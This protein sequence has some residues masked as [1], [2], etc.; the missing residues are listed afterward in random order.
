MGSRA[1][2]FMAAMLVALP[3]TSGLGASPSLAAGAVTPEG[4]CWAYVPDSDAEV[5]AGADEADS[6]F[7][8]VLASDISTQLQP[9]GLD[10]PVQTRLA[11][12]VSPDTQSSGIQGYRLTLDDGPVVVPAVP[13]DPA[14]PAPPQF[15]VE[16]EENQPAAVQVKATALFSI[17]P[18]EGLARD[19]APQLLRSPSEVVDLRP[20]APVDGLVF[21]APLPAASEGKKV[22]RLDTLVFE[23]PGEN[24]TD[25]GSV[26]VCN[27]QTEG[28]PSFPM[29]VDPAD[30]IDE[31]VPGIN[32]ATTPVPTGATAEFTPT[33]VRSV[34][35]AKVQG[36]SVTTA[37]RTGDTIEL[38]IAGLGPD[39]AFTARLC[40]S[41]GQ[42]AVEVC[43][44]ADEELVTDATGAASTSLTVPD[45]L[46]PGNAKIKIASG[47]VTQLEM[48]LAVLGPPTVA[49]SEVL[50]ADSVEVTLEGADWDPAGAVKIKG[51]VDDEKMSG[52]KGL[53][54][55]VNSDGTFSATFEVTD[56]RATQVRVQQDR[57]SGFEILEVRQAL[58]NQVPGVKSPPSEPNK[59]A[60]PQPPATDRPTPGS[61]SPPGAVSPPAL[62]PAPV[63]IPVPNEVP[64]NKVDAPPAAEALTE[65]M[66]LSEVRLDGEASLGEL[67]G[68]SSRREV[69]LLV[70]N[71]GTG[72]IA[73]PLV[74]LGVGRDAEVDPVI[75]AAEVGDLPPGARVVVSVDVALPMASFGTYQVVGQVGDSDENRFTLEWQTYPW[76]LIALNL[77][78]VALLVW[79]VR[80]RQRTRNNPAPHL[81][82]SGEDEVGASVIDITALDEWWEHGRV[83]RR[84]AVEP[85]DNDSIVDL[86]AADRWWARRDNKVS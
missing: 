20:G 48:E 41:G 75:V 52:Q 47:G 27:G 23:V 59:P 18:A 49:I 2:V 30:Q 71:T 84:A 42:S 25:P 79:G 58:D 85:D 43:A 16:G 29:P 7:P 67:F 14:V 21:S 80:R 68:G 60:Q 63:T 13:A 24:D 36:Q 3:I 62:V 37:A 74:R 11:L 33:A 45:T 50:G 81:A 39:T 44:E 51:L 77:A 1:K 78:G 82:P 54:A 26:L 66:T 15:P 17:L 5:A 64:V 19:Q 31:P 55:Q 53:T 73:N 70:E 40:H 4:G 22:L 72:A 28:Q 6:A 34:T 8:P 57:V 46:P 61:V 12:E 38:R 83:A 32:P 76:G 86:E 35:V 56:P 9:W 65:E 10:D 69:V